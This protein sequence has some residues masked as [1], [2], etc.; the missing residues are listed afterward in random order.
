MSSWTKRKC[1]LV[2]LSHHKCK[3]LTTRRFF[4]DFACLHQKLVPRPCKR[5]VLSWHKSSREQDHMLVQRPVARWN[6]EVLRASQVFCA[7]ISDTGPNLVV[8]SLAGSSRQQPLH[9]CDQT[10]SHY[11]HIYHNKQ[12]NCV[13]FMLNQLNAWWKY[14]K[15]VFY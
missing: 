9:H 6:L 7:P 15:T 13:C 2:Y 10:R 3:T 8:S 14:L 11:H 4:N 12:P 5:L 1:Y